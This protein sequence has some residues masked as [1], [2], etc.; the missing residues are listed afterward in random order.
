MY[1]YI[2]ICIYVGIFCYTYQ[3]T[4]PQS[5]R[6]RVVVKFILWIAILRRHTQHFE[7]EFLAK[8]SILLFCLALCG[9]FYSLCSNYSN[10]LSCH[11]ESS[12]VLVLAKMSYHKRK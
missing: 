3:N 12:P 9:F 11:R 10:L 7:R 8:Y 6:M 4:L 5:M 2:S 1:R